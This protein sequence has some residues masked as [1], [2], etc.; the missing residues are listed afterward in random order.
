MGKSEENGS[1]PLPFFTRGHVV[2]EHI[3]FKQIGSSLPRRVKRPRIKLQDEAS[4]MKV[5]AEDNKCN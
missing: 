4:Q 5:A 2:V 3:Y 1:P